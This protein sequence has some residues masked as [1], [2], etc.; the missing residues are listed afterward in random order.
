MGYVCPCEVLV[1][2][3]SENKN[4]K[5]LSSIGACRGNLTYLADVSAASLETSTLSFAF[6]NT[7]YPNFFNFLF[8]ANT[9]TSIACMREGGNCVVTVKGTGTVSKL[10][11]PPFPLLFEAVFTDQASPEGDDIV[12]SIVLTDFFEQKGAASVPQGTIIARGCQEVK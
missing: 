12:Q 2:A 8:T 5:F 11:F 10:P 7:D 1:N 6:E 9:I 3:V 4:V